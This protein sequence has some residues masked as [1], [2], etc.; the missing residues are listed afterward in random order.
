RTATRSTPTSPLT[1]AGPARRRSLSWHCRERLRTA[2]IDPVV[3]SSRL[4]RLARD[5][6]LATD[7]ITAGREGG[8][9]TPA[10]AGAARETTGAN[11]VEKHGERIDAE[12][13]FR[14]NKQFRHNVAF[15]GWAERYDRSMAE[16]ALLKRK[17][18]EETDHEADLRRRR[19]EVEF[20]KW[21]CNH[22]E[23]KASK[24]RSRRKDHR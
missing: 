8:G 3:S 18:R 14:R 5:E 4:A 15:N 6:R 10:S 1:S 19:A 7:V 9:V 21:L 13:L 22:A 12:Q 17:K 11:A 20:Q 23:S 24:A 2:S 16:R